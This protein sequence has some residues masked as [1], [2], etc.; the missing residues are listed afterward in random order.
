MSFFDEFVGT[1][2]EGKG[3]VF[4]DQDFRSGFAKVTHEVLALEL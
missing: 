2:L 1:C 4:W 3:I